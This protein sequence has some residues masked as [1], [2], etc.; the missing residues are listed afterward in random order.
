MPDL[1]YLNLWLRDFGEQ[2]MLAYWRQAIECFPASAQAP[3]VR[4]LAVYPLDWNQTATME[5]AF[6]DGGSADEALQLAEE[7]LHADCAY[8]ARMNWDLWLPKT[9]DPS[10]GWERKSQ[11]VSIICLGAQFAR[12]G[13]EDS[14]NLE[15][16]FGPES[17]FLPPEV[18]DLDP[19]EKHEVMASPQ[20][21]EN[22]DK[23]VGYARVIE[24]S[25]PVARRRLWSESGNDLPNQILSVWNME[26]EAG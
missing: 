6:L 3:G 5:D 26:S 7:F 11:G 15:I 23:L 2:T 9:D 8:E 18:W 24:K 16:N 17:N 1:L 12:N 10:D 21:Q 22:I 19:E 13:A 25:L 20:M 4:A 14:S